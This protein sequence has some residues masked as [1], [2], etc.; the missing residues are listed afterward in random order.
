MALW[1][2]VSR[3]V[4]LLR[5][6]TVAAVLGPTYFGNVF[7]AANLV[8]NLTYEFLTGALFTSLLVPSLVRH[9]D[10]GDAGALART[11]GGSWGWCCSAS[12][13]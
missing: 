11:A 13:R 9:V 7:Q 2:L 10:D 1:T 3:L 12:P 6:L 4:G 8:P 5:L